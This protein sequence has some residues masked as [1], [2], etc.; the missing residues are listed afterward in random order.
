MNRSLNRENPDILIVMIAEKQQIIGGGEEDKRDQRERVEL[1]PLKPATEMSDTAPYSNLFPFLSFFLLVF[2]FSYSFVFFLPLLL[3]PPSF[4][5]TINNSFFFRLF[6]FFSGP[7]EP[8][9][10]S[11]V[12]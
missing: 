10:F 4:S 5:I 2:S 6:S 9:L 3:P 1:G 8:T 7:I 12:H 11:S